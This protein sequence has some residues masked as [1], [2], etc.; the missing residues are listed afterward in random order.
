MIAG[1]VSLPETV[2]PGR[3]FA[4]RT[5]V[6]TGASSGIGEA[7]AI[8]LARR[9]AALAAAS[10]SQAALAALPCPEMR[11]FEADLSTE[12]GVQAWIENL[13]SNLSAVDVLIHAAGVI[14]PARMESAHIEDFDLQYRVNVR[15]P[16]RITQAL[17]PLLRKSRGQVVFINSSAARRAGAGVG[18][19]SAT[20][21]ALT[22]VADSLREEVNPDGVRVISVYPGRTASPMQERLHKSEVRPW[23]PGRLAQPADIAHTVVQALLLPRTAEITE[24]A[25]RPMLKD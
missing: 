22:A 12:T 23:Q 2:V 15:A 11:A 13:Q 4:G 17:L 16:Y 1:R 6:I 10:R 8:E 14:V 7:I 18:Q 5:V 25:I 21:A 20:K 9:G 3:E 19:Y 24:I